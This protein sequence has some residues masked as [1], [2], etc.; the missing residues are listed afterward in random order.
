MT[1]SNDEFSL[2]MTINCIY[3]AFIVE[4]MSKIYSVGDYTYLE[5]LGTAYDDNEDRKYAKTTFVYQIIL[6]TTNFLNGIF[7]SVATIDQSHMYL[8][9]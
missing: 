5:A 6:F 7:A 8:V 9:G 4:R 1:F 3:L 2:K